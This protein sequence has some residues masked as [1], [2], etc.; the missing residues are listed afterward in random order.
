MLR[1]CGNM[2]NQIDKI[3]ACQAMRHSLILLLLL[4]VLL[5][6]FQVLQGPGAS[7]EAL[8][9]A[10]GFACPLVVQVWDL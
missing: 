2:Q 9:H 8:K 6:A 7:M 3:A 1:P 10:G 5:H 4:F